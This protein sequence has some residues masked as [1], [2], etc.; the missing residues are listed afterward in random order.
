MT[1]QTP[2][3]SMLRVAFPRGR[4]LTKVEDDLSV[5]VQLITQ[6]SS[7]DKKEFDT[8]IDAEYA[9]IRKASVKTIRNYRTEM[10]KLLGLTLIG[11]DGIVQPSPRTLLL[12]ETQSFPLFFKTFCHRF[13]FPNAI[14]K[15]QETIKQIEAGV[16]FKPAKFI[17]DLY[18]L[19]V[20]KCGPSFSVSGNEISN[21]V[22]NDIRVTSGK[23]NASHVLDTLLGLRKGKVSFAGGSKIAQHGREFLNYMLLAQLLKEGDAGEFILN[24]NE[25][26]AIDIIRESEFF[27]KMPE[28]YALDAKIRKNTQNEWISWFGGVSLIEKEKLS[29]SSISKI[30]TIA[31]PGT[32]INKEDIALATPS[33]KDLKG[34]GD[35]GEYIV[36]KYEKE[37]IAQ[38]RPDKIGLVQRVANDTA[39]GYDIQSLE[40]TDVSKK[41]FIEV[42]TTERTYP[43]AE[44]VLTFFPMSANEWE[45][46][47]SLGESYY[48]YRVFL[49]AKEPILYV[50]KNPVKEEAK[51]NII[52]ETLSYRV[53]VKKQA[54]TYIK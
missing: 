46:A 54:G 19:G 9:K 29:I 11:A 21:L 44:E 35:K 45:T 34:I 8:L 4:M 13:V 24:R 42:K 47:R 6:F 31:V 17:L 2:A 28:E 39:L 36:L 37:R 50:I 33:M 48:V 25:Q 7:R 27:F 14:N 16:H 41:K 15:P 1:F 23:I 22:F 30:Q 43:P 38:I 5:L 20:A 12:I 53:I 26:S 3:G 52:L 49:T 10:T 32:E 40:F 18:M 51:G